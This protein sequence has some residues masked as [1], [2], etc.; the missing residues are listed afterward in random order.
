[1]IKFN[2]ENYEF[3]TFDPYS[4]DHLKAKTYLVTDLS[5]RKY[6]GD[7]S[8]ILQSPVSTGLTDS[9]FLV[10]RNDKIVGYLALFDYYKHIDMH[11][12]VISSHRGFKYSLTE[13]T[14]AS[15]VREASD[16]L[17]KLVPA[18]EFIRLYIDKNN[19]NS[20]RA[21]ESAGFKLYG[22]VHPELETDIYKKYRR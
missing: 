7:I 4:L 2:T 3:M 10:A 21:A 12:A 18:I 9:A 14:G 15:I 16:E 20:R 19:I 1:M 17:F 11:Y 22:E 5:V 13:T 6:L 8:D